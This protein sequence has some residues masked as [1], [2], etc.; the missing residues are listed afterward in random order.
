[1]RFGSQSWIGLALI[2][3]IALFFLFRSMISC[4]ASFLYS[5][6]YIGICIVR[7]TELNLQHYFQVKVLT[8]ESCG[9]NIKY[10]KARVYKI[11]F[12]TPVARYIFSFDSEY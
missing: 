5:R 1:M 4:I 7:T 11:A 3:L 6:E 10:H 9:T 12:S 2:P 8:S